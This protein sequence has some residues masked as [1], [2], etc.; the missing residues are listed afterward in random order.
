MGQNVKDLFHTNY[1]EYIYHTIHLP[2]HMSFH[3]KS[4]LSMEVFH[5]TS[6]F[7]IIYLIL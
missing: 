2:T 3:N 1:K 7:F 6:Q 4:A 5:N